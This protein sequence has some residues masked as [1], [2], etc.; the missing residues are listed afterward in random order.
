QTEKLHKKKINVVEAQIKALEHANGYL[1][2]I[3]FSDGTKATGK[4]LYARLPFVQHS[5][6]PRALGCKIT[7]EG[8]LKTDAAQRTSV[9]GVYACGD[10]TTRMRTVANAVSTG[11][12]TGIMVNNALIDEDF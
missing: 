5:T 11:T 8:Y 12:T 2:N 4:A 6:I 9:Q 10:N 1:Q 7:P 3:V